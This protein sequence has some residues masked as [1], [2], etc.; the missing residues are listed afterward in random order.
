MFWCH[1]DDD[2][3]DGGGDYDDDGGGGGYYVGGDDGGDY[4]DENDDSPS[5]QL[6]AYLMSEVSELKYFDISSRSG[7]LIQLTHDHE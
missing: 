6:R 4:V 2:D 1:D 3:D 7:T 5:H